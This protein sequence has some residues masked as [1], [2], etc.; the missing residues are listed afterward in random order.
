MF[1][2]D[3]ASI[4]NYTDRAKNRIR[5]LE[6]R[7]AKTY[8]DP[9]REQRLIKYECRVCFYTERIC[10]QGFTKYTCAGC[11]IELSHPNTCVPRLCLSC[12]QVEEVCRNC[13]ADLEL[14][15]RTA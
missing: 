15:K 10:G 13:G 5:H 8:K 1:K 14:K 9:N 2:N 7:I 12:A 3:A 6:E 4:N 11:N